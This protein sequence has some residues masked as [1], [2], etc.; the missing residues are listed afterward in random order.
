MQETRYVLLGLWCFLETES[1]S[2]P[3]G[4][5]FGGHSWSALHCSMPLTAFSNPPQLLSTPLH[6]A[7]RTG[8][9]DCAEHLIACE[10]DL[11]ARDRV[12][13]T[14]SLPA[15]PSSWPHL[16]LH[17]PAKIPGGAVGSGPW[18]W[19]QDG[20]WPVSCTPRKVTHRCMMPSGWTAT[21]WSGCWF[22][23]GRTWP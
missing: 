20:L 10:A 7:V 2:L 3:E 1:W 9:Y 11:N 12:S 13:A 8:Q 22:S 15:A 4:I 21:K 18:H 17:S 5:I 23:M 16:Q 14:T 19:W 6:V